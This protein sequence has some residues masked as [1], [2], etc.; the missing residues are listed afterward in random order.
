MNPEPTGAA[1]PSLAYDRAMAFWF[2]RIN[3][4]VR[5]PR[6]ADLK[7]D[8]MRA[9][10]HLLGD[11]HRRVRVV[12]VAGSKGK[13]STCAFAAA[14]LQAAGHRVGR[15]TSPH[16]H[17]FRE[18]IA[19]DGEPIAEAAFAALTERAEREAAVLEQERSELGAVTAFELATASKP[20]WAAPWTRPTL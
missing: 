1:A 5:T 20:G 7:L 15:Y 11:P 2:G 19:V 16:L 13:G 14:I 10:M 8:R 9:L 17:T 3:Y 12:H 18:R 6:P 4:E